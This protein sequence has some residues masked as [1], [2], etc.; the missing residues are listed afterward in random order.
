MVRNFV[1]RAQN[2]GDDGSGSDEIGPG[3]MFNGI[4]RA[5]CQLVLPN[6]DPFYFVGA[7]FWYGMNLGSSNGARG[8]DRKRLLR[9]LDAMKAAGVR[10]LRVLASSEGPAD[11]PQH[12]R[13]FPTLLLSSQ[14]KYD[15]E[16]LQGLDFLLKEMR[17]RGMY[18]VMVLNNMWWWSGGWAQYVHWAE[19]ER[20]QS[21]PGSAQG[22]AGGGGGTTPG[23]TSCSH[24]DA[25]GACVPGGGADASSNAL[26][27]GEAIPY[28]GVGG[29]SWADFEEYSM[30]FLSDSVAQEIFRAHVRFLLTRTNSFTQLA[31]NQD[32]TILAWELANEPRGPSKAPWLLDSW[33]QDTSQLLRQL[34]RQLVTT[35]SE[36]DTPWPEESGID[37]AR[38]HAHVGVDY[39]TLHLW[40]QN[41]GWFDPSNGTE[42]HFQ[43]AVQQG[44]RYLHEML[45]KSRAL[46]KPVVLEEFGMARDGG[47]LTTDAAAV[48][49]RDRYF[50][51]I[52]DEVAAS[53]RQG[54]CLAGGIFWAWGGEGMPAGPAWVDGHR[55]SG[56][57]WTGDPPHEPQGWYS[58]FMS[59]TSTLAVLDDV[60]SK[61]SGAAK[62]AVH[63]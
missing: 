63:P 34:T 50:Q 58:V 11:A 36:G 31:Y 49:N 2:G 1:L 28:P 57:E 51:A 24:R 48:S 21:L 56:K 22:A 61:V 52:L 35:G 44:K 53:A 60:A 41:W 29:A 47:L 59:D 38:N 46:N 8:G 5:G 55:A 15:P 37:I 19:S 27:A 62:Y 3:E 40:V 23:D 42:D 26:G 13:L 4:K 14:L 45:D 17:K 18:A 10:V 33:I 20:R 6:G 9:E 25:S 7:N 32:K 30:R 16:L 39:V 54:D 43:E 12:Q